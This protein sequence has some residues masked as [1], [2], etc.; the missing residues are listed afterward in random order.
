[1]STER[2]FS[3]RNPWFTGSVGLAAALFL[4]SGVG[5]LVVLP[6]AQRDVTFAGI[7]DAICSAAGVAQST[8]SK[9]AIEPDFKISSVVV[10]ATMLSRPTPDSVGRGA[11][12]AQQC[13]ICH[14]PVGVSRAD[15]P[16]LAGQYP[17]AIYKQLKDFKSGARVN[18]TMTPFAV[19]LTEQD[20]VDLTAY[21]AYLPRLPA[22]HPDKET[23]APRI[24]LNGAPLRNVASCGSCHGGLDNKT[25][26]PWL[27]GQSV[28]YIKAQLQAF[29]SGTRRN[30]IS[31]QMRN[32]ARQMTPEEIDAAARYYASQP[33]NAQHATN[34]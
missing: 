13:A 34:P 25:G 11:T 22:Y 3:L 1:M 33:P 30:D 7:W 14:G 2:L 31:Q 29:A 19:P 4:V 23:P 9:S 10:T 5:G 32:I 12:L 24:V 8:S 26:S 15:S 6:Y 21:Y 18:A 28:V 16:N 27:E 20:M 17:A